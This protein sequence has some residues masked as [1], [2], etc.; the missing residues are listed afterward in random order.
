MQDA[1]SRQGR[2]LTALIFW[3]VVCASLWGSAFPG[4]K[5][6]YSHYE[7]LTLSFVLAFAGV[8]FVIA[9]GML[10]I[11]YAKTFRRIFVHRSGTIWGKLI[12]LI[13]FQTVFQYL[14]F[15]KAM[16]LSS[17]VLGSILIGFGSI[18]WLVLSPVFLQTPWPD[19]FNW[20]AIGLSMAG[21]GIAVYSPGI[22]E[23]QPILG[24]GLFLL[25]SLSGAGAAITIR[26]LPNGFPIPLVTGISLFIGGLILTLFGISELW[27]FLATAKKGV[28]L[29]TLW[30]SL[31][32]AA[33]FAIWNTLISQYSVELLAQFRFLIPIS[34]VL[35]SIAFIPGESL[36][37]GVC[38]GGF[39]VVG[40]I[41]TTTRH[42]HN[43]G[44]VVN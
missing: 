16:A 13:L 37:F 19:R 23:G 11:I 41:W 18:W 5:Y 25:A 22:G 30:L 44:K 10:C 29:M 34:G 32:S 9:G 17:G 2:S 7:E 21:A 39:L 1:A 12:L 36:S 33:A 28:V 3:V 6:V 31:V 14:F 8:R 35:Q 38:F 27:E 40:A 26:K 15:Y 43:K 20:I 42:V 4:I 24:G